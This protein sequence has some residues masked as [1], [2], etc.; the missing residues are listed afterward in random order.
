MYFAPPPP[1]P[2]IALPST[3]HYDL[4][5]C[6]ITTH[7]QL[8]IVSVFVYGFSLEMSRKHKTLLVQLG[9]HKTKQ[10]PANK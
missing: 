10:K 6:P 3:R 9:C 8:R 5:L 7:I 4:R 1:L 2:Y